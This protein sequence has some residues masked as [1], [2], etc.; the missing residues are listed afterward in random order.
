MPE[1]IDAA[2][3]AV[4]ESPQSA[5]AQFVS[6]QVFARAGKNEEAARAF[7]EIAT[8]SAGYRCAIAARPLASRIRGQ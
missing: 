4:R 7:D 5:E 8:E 3:R 2:S 6:G 1:A